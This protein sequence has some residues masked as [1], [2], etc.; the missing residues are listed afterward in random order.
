MADRKLDAPLLVDAGGGA[1]T[2]LTP[3]EVQT[4]AAGGDAAALAAGIARRQRQLDTAV[5]SIVV[6]GAPE[7]QAT[8]VAA[9]QGTNVALPGPDGS[10]SPSKMAPETRR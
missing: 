6:S 4:Y 2:G 5:D 7:L 3:R 9:L 8:V 10:L 1:V